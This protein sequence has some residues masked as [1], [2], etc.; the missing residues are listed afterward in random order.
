MKLSVVSVLVS[1][2]AT[3]S[4]DVILADEIMGIFEIV[5]VEDLVWALCITR[6]GTGG[7]SIEAIGVVETIGLVELVGAK[8]SV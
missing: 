7:G 1:V 8:V 2:V 6:A 5:I 3:R 4:V